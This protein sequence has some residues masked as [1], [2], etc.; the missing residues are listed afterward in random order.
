MRN[1]ASH[2]V[3]ALPP[4]AETILLY[5]ADGLSMRQG[6]LSPAGRP[7]PLKRS[8][9]VPLFYRLIKSP[10]GLRMLHA[11]AESGMRA[12]DCS[13]D[14]LDSLDGAFEDITFRSLSHAALEHYAATASE[15]IDLSGSKRSTAHRI[16]PRPLPTN[17]LGNTPLRHAPRTSGPEHTLHH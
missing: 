12:W 15:R 5:A 1:G 16:T 13:N 11:L 7:K 17:L 9:W 2:R 4:P 10:R 14:M 3:V 8:S 6:H